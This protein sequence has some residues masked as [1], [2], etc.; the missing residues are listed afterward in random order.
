MTARTRPAPALPLRLAA[1]TAAACGALARTVAQISTG[2]ARLDRVA[3]L[4]ALS[5]GEL[6]ALGVARGDIVR[7]VFADLFT[8]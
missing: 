4:R 3:R 7:H 8:E 1:R 5:D 6:A 2:Q